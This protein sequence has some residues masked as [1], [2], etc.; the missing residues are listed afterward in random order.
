[1]DDIFPLV[2]DCWSVVCSKEVNMTS[3]MGEAL[4][5]AKAEVVTG[6]QNALKKR[7][8]KVAARTALDVFILLAILVLNN[9]RSLL[10][11]IYL[12][13]FSNIPLVN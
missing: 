12:A 13:G 7:M 11:V 4:L 10:S 1:M 6:K 2:Q 3:C 5:P 8:N 9:I